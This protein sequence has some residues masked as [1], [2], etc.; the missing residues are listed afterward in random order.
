MVVIGSDISIL[1]NKI[2]CFHQKESTDTADNNH[3]GSAPMGRG[4]ILALKGQ[5]VA[6]GDK[7]HVYI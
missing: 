4:N 6:Y 2:H 1:S 5:N 3:N 7:S